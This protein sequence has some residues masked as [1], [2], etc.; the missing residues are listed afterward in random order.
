MS[1]NRTKLHGIHLNVIYISV[2]LS[3]S[4]INVFKYFLCEDISRDD[5]S[6]S[7]P[8]G[9]IVETSSDHICY[10]SIFRL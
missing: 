2:L 5:K 7:M 8:C 10:G 3:F 6:Y 9:L 4:V 1:S